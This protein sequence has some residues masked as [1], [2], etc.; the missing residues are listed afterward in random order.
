VTAPPPS[1]IS[2]SPSRIKVGTS[3]DMSVASSPCFPLSGV[4]LGQVSIDPT[5]GIS[6]L[7]LSNVT[8]RSLT[9][10]FAIDPAG[11]SGTR[12]VTIN[13]PNGPQ[14]AQF[15]VFAL[16]VCPPTQQCCVKND[17]GSCTDCRNLCVAKGC[18]PP[19]PT[20][21]GTDP[22]NLLVCTDCQAGSHCK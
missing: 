16:R 4:G 9:L 14:S 12:T 19:T 17:E 21:C 10:S 8:A 15:T 2:V 11:L 1:S 13:T 22:N 5:D 6:G 20:C 18:S 7:R 3:T